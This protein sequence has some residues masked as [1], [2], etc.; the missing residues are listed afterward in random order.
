M[1]IDLPPPDLAMSLCSNSLEPTLGLQRRAYWDEINPLLAKWRS[2]NDAKCPEYGRVIKV[3]MSRHLLMHTKYVCYWR[4]PVPACPLW[5]TLELNGKDRIEHTHRF[6]EWRGHSFYECLRKFGLEWCGS[7][8]FFEQRKV[9]GQAFWLNLA[10][11]RRSGQKLS[12]S[13]KITG[14][15][16]FSPMRRFFNAAVHQL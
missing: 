10:L 12:N 5:F 1:G 9:T 15:P 7:C 8:G 6:R 13:Y 3:N 14:S 11:A 4:C 2:V 16:A